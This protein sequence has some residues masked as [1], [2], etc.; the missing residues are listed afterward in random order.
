MKWSRLALMGCLVRMDGSVSGD[1]RRFV[2]LADCKRA[3]QIGQ[4]ETVGISIRCKMRFLTKH[5]ADGQRVRH[6][7]RAADTLERRE[8][9]GSGAWDLE[10]PEGGVQGARADGLEHGLSPHGLRL[11]L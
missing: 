11:R 6:D 2:K 3:R 10:D 5:A 4:L 9:A 8:D 7:H 1:G